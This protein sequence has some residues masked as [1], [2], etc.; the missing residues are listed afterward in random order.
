ML[1]I[2]VIFSNNNISEEIKDRY[3]RVLKGHIAIANSIFPK[4]TKGM[5]L[6][7]LARKYLLEIG[8]NYSHGTGHGVGSF[9]GVHEGPQNISPLGSEEI[10]K[11]M[12]ISNEPGYY[13]ENE[14]GIRIENLVYVKEDKKN[15]NL[16]YFETLTMSPIDKSLIDKNLLNIKE[17]NWLNNYHSKVLEKISPFLDIDEK[18]WLKKSCDAIH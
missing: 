6:D 14:Y 8:L 16:L 9:L 4:G 15:N 7:P 11:G 2:I 5:D 18:I 10:R 17:K 1:Q 13:K 3:T 12:I